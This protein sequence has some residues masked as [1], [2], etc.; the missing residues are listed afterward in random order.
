M[1][2]DIKL[3]VLNL[4]PFSNDATLILLGLVIWLIIV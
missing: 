1:Y 4:F 3:Q 2:G